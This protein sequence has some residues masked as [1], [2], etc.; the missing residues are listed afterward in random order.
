MFGETSDDWLLMAKLGVSSLG[1]SLVIISLRFRFLSNFCSPLVPD[2]GESSCFSE[3]SPN[4]SE[5]KFL[6]D[7][8]VDYLVVSYS[9]SY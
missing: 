4:C 3:F 8:T 9:P 1:G 2:D 7:L 6:V 5:F